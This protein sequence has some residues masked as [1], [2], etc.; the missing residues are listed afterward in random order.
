MKSILLASASIFA[1][2]G[3]AAAEVTFAGSATLGY[4]DTDNLAED[5]VGETGDD[6]I[7][8]YWDANVAVTLSQEL[9]NGVTAS[10]TFDFDVADM[11]NGQVL[12]FGWLPA[13]DHLRHGRPLLRRHHVRCRDLLGLRWRHGSRRVL[14]S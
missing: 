9:D 8:F 5:G 1:F 2:V 13:V 4:N 3:A 10:A 14:R 7:G 12:E 6:E 11:N